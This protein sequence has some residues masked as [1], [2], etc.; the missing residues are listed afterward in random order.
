[1]SI[2][3]L[4][5]HNN[6]NNTSTTINSYLCLCLCQSL[7]PKYNTTTT[8]SLPLDKKQQQQQQQQI[9][10]LLSLLLFFF[11]RISSSTW[12]QQGISRLFFFFTSTHMNETC[13]SFSLSLSL[14]LQT[15]SLTSLCSSAPPHWQS[16]AF[17]SDNKQNVHHRH[18]LRQLSSLVPF[19]L[20]LLRI[21]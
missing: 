7:S 6:N 16:S 20:V 2:I 4:T 14:F 1:V 13:H 11:T 9:Q 18:R 8:K 19:L 3:S 10:R 17:V 21:A 12:R 15:S 5:P